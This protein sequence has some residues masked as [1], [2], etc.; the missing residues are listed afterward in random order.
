MA[1]LNKTTT[2]VTSYVV[3]IKTLGT[4]DP[5]VVDI[6]LDLEDDI[7]TNGV[8]VYNMDANFGDETTVMFMISKTDAGFNIETAK[9]F[10]DEGQLITEVDVTVRAATH[11]L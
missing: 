2:V 11:R 6:L 7:V 10:S 8:F 4:E 1:H 3:N 5:E 9:D